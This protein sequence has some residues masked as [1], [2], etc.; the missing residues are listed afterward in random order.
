M[1]K[2]TIK[3]TE[4]FGGQEKG[5]EMKVD[6]LLAS[7]LV[8]RREV[9][10]YTGDSLERQKKSK[11]IVKKS[12]EKDAKN[13]DERLS[14]IDVLKKK[15]QEATQSPEKTEKVEEK[16]EEKKAEA[17]KPEDKKGFLGFGK[18]S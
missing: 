15:A 9:A 6:S 5:H 8:N 4:D 16:V 11:A 3:L 12:E 2:D 17:K 13:E 18:K 14:K 10:V 7:S 1:A